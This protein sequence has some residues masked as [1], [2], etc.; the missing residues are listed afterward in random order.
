MEYFGILNVAWQ[1]LRQGII[2][3]SALNAKDQ[4]RDK[5]FYF[6]KLHTLKYFFHYELIKTKSLAIR[7]M[8]DELITV[9]MDD[10]YLM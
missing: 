3:Q 10:E 5:S 2:A 9:V 6:S 7:L 4:L 1:W 8:D